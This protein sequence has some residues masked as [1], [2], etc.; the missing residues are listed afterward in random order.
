MKTLLYR[1]EGCPP[2]ELAVPPGYIALCA[3]AYL[4]P[5]LAMFAPNRLGVLW[6]P[7]K[8]GG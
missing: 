1:L 4:A 6:F 5:G 8:G 2:E 3:R 7:A